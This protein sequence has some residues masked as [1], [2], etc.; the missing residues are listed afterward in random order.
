MLWTKARHEDLS[1]HLSDST[2]FCSQVQSVDRYGP[3]G[4]VPAAAPNGCGNKRRAGARRIIVHLAKAVPV[5][6]G[7]PYDDG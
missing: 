3:F 1:I 2:P 4:Q 5:S 6:S 7:T